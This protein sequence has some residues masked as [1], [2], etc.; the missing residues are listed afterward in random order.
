MSN[1][2]FK[3]A[4]ARPLAEK[5]IDQ[6]LGISYRSVN[7]FMTEF[8]TI[9]AHTANQNG[10]LLKDNWRQQFEETLHFLLE[11][12]DKIHNPFIAKQMVY[13]ARLKYCKTITR[14]EGDSAVLAK[15]IFKDKSLKLLMCSIADCV[16]TLTSKTCLVK[17]KLEQME[18]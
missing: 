1:P 7:E 6:C 8:Y 2:E 3:I 18:A 15:A 10:I 14:R 11:L 17:D 9:V 5:I 13:H 4:S 16:W 12:S